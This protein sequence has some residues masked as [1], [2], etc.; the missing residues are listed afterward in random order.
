MMMEKGRDIIGKEAEV[1]VAS[2]N[3]KKG[4]DWPEVRKIVDDGVDDRFLQKPR[5]TTKYVF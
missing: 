5:A 4:V 1:D 3:L 2:W